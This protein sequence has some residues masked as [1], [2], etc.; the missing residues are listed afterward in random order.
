MISTILMH[1]LL[2]KQVQHICNNQIIRASQYVNYCTKDYS[3]SSKLDG[4]LHFYGQPTDSR[5]FLYVDKVENT[6]MSIQI[7]V[8]QLS[9]FAI[10]GFTTK[11]EIIECEFKVKIVENLIQTASISIQ[12]DILISHS[13]VQFIANGL[14]VSGLIMKA[15]DIITIESC[16]IQFRTKAQL[17][18]A[19]VLLISQQ[20]KQ[21]SISNVFI[22]SHFQNYLNTNAVLVSQIE[23]V[24]KI[25]VV[26]QKVYYCDL[27]VNFIQS[28]HES[29]IA[30]SQSPTKRCDLCESN[31]FMVYGI[32]QNVSLEFGE[33][34]SGVYI[35]VYPFIYDGQFCVCVS[36][37]QL[38][39]DECWQ[40][41]NE[42]LDQYIAGNFTVLD[43]RIASNTSIL[44]DRIA[45]NMT[46]GNIRMQSLQATII[47]NFYSLSSNII[48]N[49]SY[50]E[51]Q[52]IN[53]FTLLNN[54][55]KSN[56]TQ[57][58]NQLAANKNYLEANL[59]SNFS[60]ANSNLARNATE[61]DNRIR[62]NVTSLSNSI[63][64]LTVKVND[65]LALITSNLAANKQYLEI[66]LLNNASKVNAAITSGTA[67]IRTDLTNVNS[68]LTT[69][70][71]NLRNDLNWVNNDLNSQMTVT[72]NNANNVQARINVVVNDIGGLR[73]VDNSIQNQINAISARIAQ[74][75]WRVIQ[76]PTETDGAMINTLQLC[77]NGDCRTV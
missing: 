62:A 59:I 23:N 33:N 5:I 31:E 25:D 15:S 44:D 22:S 53:N 14:S 48:F 70:T 77:V 55:I 9:S 27:I 32:C 56:T 13:T 68:A 36:G 54:N 47:S 49:K 26:I 65:N 6:V 41:V 30:F 21:F 57:L 39:V 29:I 74:V 61:L 37:N 7:N 1:K 46:A 75:Y 28:Q 73:V 16:K 51:T 45:M 38:N 71:Q 43:Q 42:R 3:S 18:A 19:V 76:T 2:N 66:Q 8:P 69:L 24:Q 20:V 58:N 40:I 60:Q 67:P 17:S 10:F 4:V 35:C 34:V 63:N 72:T 11:T 64:T 12:C 52:I 50:Q